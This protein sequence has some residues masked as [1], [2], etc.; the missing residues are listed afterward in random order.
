MS[1][2]VSSLLV[3]GLACG[4][5]SPAPDAAP[6][7]AGGKVGKN[8]APPAAAPAEASPPAAG[9]DVPAGAVGTIDGKAVT[10]AAA[11]AITEPSGRVQLVAYERPI[12]CAEYHDVTARNAKMKDAL[13]VAFSVPAAA[14]TWALPKLSGD[15]RQTGNAGLY[16]G[17]NGGL[18]GSLV[19]KA[20][21][22]DVVADFDVTGMK[23]VFKG[24]TRFVACAKG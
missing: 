14:G 16:N 20:E 19:T 24:S 13:Y 17:L 7:A 5:G 3:F 11:F 15:D 2:M 22:A 6:P 9:G 12:T 18:G 10:V 21:G 1:K 4:G 23:M 8:D